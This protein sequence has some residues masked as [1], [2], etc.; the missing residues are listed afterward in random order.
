MKLTGRCSVVKKLELV[1]NPIS[2]KIGSE[3]RR[4]GCKVFVNVRLVGVG[5]AGGCTLRSGLGIV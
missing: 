1:Y 4:V 5:G 2:V 3:S